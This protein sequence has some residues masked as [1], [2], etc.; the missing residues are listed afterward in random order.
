MRSRGRGSRSKLYEGLPFLRELSLDA[1]KAIAASVAGPRASDIRPLSQLYVDEVVNPSQIRRLSQAVAEHGMEVLLDVPIRRLVPSSALLRGRLVGRTETST[2]VFNGLLEND[3]LKW[4][5]LVATRLQDILSMRGMGRSAAC[6]VLALAI[7]NGLQAANDDPVAV[8]N[9]IASSPLSYQK[10]NKARGVN[11]T[12]LAELLEEFVT[13]LPASSL[14]ARIPKGTTRHALLQLNGTVALGSVRDFLS[15]AEGLDLLGRTF[16]TARRRS[17]LEE[18]MR[19]FDSAVLSWARGRAWDQL[20]KWVVPEKF[21]S[22]NIAHEDRPL[23]SRLEKS[24]GLGRRLS[25]ASGVGTWLPLMSIEGVIEIKKLRAPDT[26]H[27]LSAIARGLVELGL[28]GRAR[29]WESRFPTRIEAL[30]ITWMYQFSPTR[31]METLL[32]RLQRGGYTNIGHLRTL[33]PDALPL[34]RRASLSEWVAL[35]S[36]LDSSS[37]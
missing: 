11:G 16:S 10:L 13:S 32:H 27:M 2:R 34:V 24:T 19:H 23:R 3:L 6:E 22:W 36:E 15:G 7:R 35:R 21:R 37:V 33:H 18:S 17:T 30:P 14:A 8:D 5:K 28:D 20:Y 12:L 25:V 31:R 26:P 29:P 9:G 1:R 4:E